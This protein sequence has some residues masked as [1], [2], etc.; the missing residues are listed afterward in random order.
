MWNIESPKHFFI[1]YNEVNL[2]TAQNL[3]KLG[4][5]LP[6][7]GITI[8]TLNTSHPF[9]RFLGRKWKKIRA[10]LGLFWIFF[11]QVVH[12]FY[13]VFWVMTLGQKI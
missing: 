8:I 13:R 2:F 3:L 1:F 10:N 6:N 11:Y 9:K 12:S 5:Q 7:S 4:P